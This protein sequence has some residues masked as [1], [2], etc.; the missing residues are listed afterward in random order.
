MAKKKV[1]S[2]E[3]RIPKLKQARK[4]KA[5]RRLIFYLSLFFLLISIITYLQSPLS[6]VKHFEVEGNYFITDGEVLAESQLTTE[7]NIWQIDFQT[8]ERNI[9]K[10]PEIKQATVTR[11]FPRTVQIE[12]EEYIRVGY[13]KE[14]DRFYP[15]LENGERLLN[16]QNDIPKGDA[17]VL[18][19][20]NNDTYLVEMTDEL[21]GLE[22]SIASQ[23]SEIHWLN[24]ET[25]PYKIRLFMMN[26]QEVVAS[27]RN[28][29]QKMGV[30]PSIIAKL[31]PEQRG[32]VHIDVGAFFI[33]YERD[34]EELQDVSGEEQVNESER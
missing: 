10:H 13:V 19:G 9:L 31:K 20:W 28:F 11:K 32:V 26:G 27:I 12:L 4:K 18:I 15:I 22:P 14:G 21:R 17:P 24:D 29:A 7:Y 5:N 2:I 23:I 1:V 34:S 33:P 30:Y 6:H 3:E 25:N 16:Q 8:I